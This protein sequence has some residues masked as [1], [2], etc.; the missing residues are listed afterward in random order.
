MK[1]SINVI[2]HKLWC[3]DKNYWCLSIKIVLNSSL[4]IIGCLYHSPSASDAKFVEDFEDYL[5]L[6]FDGKGRSVLVGDFNLN[7]V[8]ENVYVNKFKNVMTRL[9]IDQIVNQY[10]RITNTSATLIDWVLTNSTH[11]FAK[12]HDC[13][14][15]SDHLIISI[16]VSR[17]VFNI[18]NSFLQD[19]ITFRKLTSE[20]LNS[21]NLELLSLSWPLESTDVDFILNE[22]NNNCKNVINKLAPLQVQSLSH[23]NKIPW[24]DN[25]VKEVAKL[26]DN[27]YKLFKSCRNESRNDLW[28]NYKYFRNRCVNLL[29][30][31]KYDYFN[32]KIIKCKNSFDM[33]KVLKELVNAKNNNCPKFIEFTQDNNQRVSVSN[34]REV[35]TRFN[36]FFK[37][38]IVDIVKSIP[39]CRDWDSS[40][41]PV[42]SSNFSN[43]KPLSIA[44]LNKIISSLK[45]NNNTSEILNSKIIKSVSNVI[46]HVILHFVNTSLEKG[47]FP[48]ELKC[49]LISP[50]PKVGNSCKAENFR[51]INTLPTIEKVLEI[52]VYNQISRYFENNHIIF[53]FQSGFRKNHS[54][55]SALQ[56]TVATIKE[57]IDKDYY[58]VA[59]FL[60]F[61]RAFETIDRSILLN[62]LEYFGIKD[63]VL[64]WFKDY[65]CYRSQKLKFSSSVSDSLFIDHGVPQGSVLGPLLFL[66]YINDLYLHVNCD[67][68]NLFADDTLLMCCS[69]NLSDAINKMNVALGNVSQYLQINK[70]KLNVSKSKAVIF[71]TNYKYSTIDLNNFNI[72]V[73]DDSVD[74]VNGIKYLGCILD[75]TLSFKTHVEYIHKKISKKLF[76]FS[77]IASNLTL[78]TKITV[79]N[80]II[81]PHFDYC[82]SLIYLANKKC[83]E[84]LQKLQNRGMRIIF[85]CSKYTPIKTMLTTLNWLSVHQRL[86]YFAMLFVY[87]IINNLLPTYFN[88]YIIY[89]K[90]IHNYNT[91]TASNIYLGKTNLKKTMNNLFFK[92]FI[93]YN[94]LPKHITDSTS[95]KIFKR[96]LKNYIYLL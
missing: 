51:P 65:L 72:K 13:P 48:R 74:I 36:N 30:K 59:A 87:K 31:N 68:I 60:D 83:I 67:F 6:M 4:W 77:R 33:W 3:I 22:I 26:R 12:I 7:F 56:I 23:K 46:G 89:V 24:Y 37:N 47:I 78:A 16:N 61:Q 79:Y 76:F 90:E 28:N 55:E 93:E 80:S 91:R 17:N 40:V 2:N 43:F 54:C 71:T 66:V 29:K 14:K 38:S 10:T 41:L 75:N 32:N 88:K 5:E 19:K 82:A 64:R 18:N 39:F 25:S 34:A 21:I 94:K 50:I 69:S 63:N 1:D 84:D 42:V 62:K 95:V 81:Q 96:K 49:S 20:V 86:F 58:V 57:Y 45:Y 70:L 92:G 11:I 85:T 53:T 15:I 8:S 44:D 73:N 35:C 27:A 9:G 52:A